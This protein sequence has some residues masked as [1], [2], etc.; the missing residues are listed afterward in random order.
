MTGEERDWLDPETRAILQPTP[1]LEATAVGTESYALLLI[2]RGGDHGRIEQTLD[3][4]AESNELEA[5]D[6]SDP[7]HVEDAHAPQIVARHLSLDEA[8]EAQFDLAS[9]DCVTAFVADEVV[10][11]ADVEYLSRLCEAVLTSPEFAPVELKVLEIPDTAAGRRFGWQ[12]LGMA[13]ALASP[14]TVRVLRK[15]ARLMSYW[16]AKCGVRVEGLFDTG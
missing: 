8:L 5:A 4:L 11:S 14:T 15:K 16:A 3:R 13:M 2:Q 12:F 6:T 10:E 7:D 9:C 1:P